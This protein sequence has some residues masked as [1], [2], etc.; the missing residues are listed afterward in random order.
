MGRTAHAPIRSVQSL[1]RIVQLLT[2]RFIPQGNATEIIA[3]ANQ[4]VAALSS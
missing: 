3:L 2:P 1:I 4:L